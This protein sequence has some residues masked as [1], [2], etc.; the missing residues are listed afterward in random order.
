MNDKRARKYIV[1]YFCVLFLLC[2]MRTVCC[3]YREESVSDHMQSYDLDAGDGGLEGRYH[4][5]DGPLV[6]SGTALRHIVYSDRYPYSVSA[7]SYS[8]RTAFNVISSISPGIFV[9]PVIFTM[10]MARHLLC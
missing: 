3:V 8:S 10:I 7:P 5:T 2:G 1:S 6:N 4:L 9:I